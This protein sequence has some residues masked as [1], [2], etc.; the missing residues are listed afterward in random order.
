MGCLGKR[1]SVKDL[2]LPFDLEQISGGKSIKNLH[3][4]AFL[5]N[6]HTVKFGLVFGITVCSD[7]FR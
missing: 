3:V 5:Q 6:L 1:H 7:F 2:V 4:V